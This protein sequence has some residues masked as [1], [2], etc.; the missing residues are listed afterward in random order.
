MVGTKPPRR[1]ALW[2]ARLL[3]EHLVVMMDEVCGASNAKARRELDWEPAHR[4][5]RDGFGDLARA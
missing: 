3:G 4:S 1:I 5:W 2:L